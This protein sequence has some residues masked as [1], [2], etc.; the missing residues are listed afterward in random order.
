MDFD[1]K[2]GDFSLMGPEAWIALSEG[3]WTL[4]APIPTLP[5]K[6]RMTV[7]RLKD[8]SL[9]IHSCIALTEE[10][11]AKLESFGTP[12]VLIIPNRLHDLDA[13]YYKNRYPDLRVLTPALSM[14]DVEKV[15]TPTGDYEQF[16]VDHTTRVETLDGSQ[17]GEGAFVHQ[18][19]NEISLVFNDTL[20]NVPPIRGPKGWL[21]RLLGSTGGPRVTPLARWTL[22]SDKHRLANHLWHLS[23]LPG[24]KRIIP[25]HGDVI[26]TDAAQTLEAVARKLGKVAPIG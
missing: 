21:M 14:K 3:L 5:F 2:S 6:R 13:R 15:I 9:A 4:E 16:P 26:E 7:F 11:F 1:K 17:G 18:A 25:G 22:V 12:S 8:R 20:F 19:D 10:G 23:Q 24:L